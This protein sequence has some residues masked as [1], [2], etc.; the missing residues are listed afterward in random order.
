MAIINELALS[1]GG[2]II[3]KNQQSQQTENTVSI[4]IGLGGTGI[5][6]VREIKTQVYNRIK[7]DNDGGG[8]DA[9]YDHIK[10]IGVDADNVKY[11]DYDS[12]EDNLMRSRTLDTDE[13]F[14]LAGSDAML[15][16]TQYI[17]EKYHECAWVSRK[18]E[19]LDPY[20]APGTGGIRQVGRFM[21]M[22]K[23]DDFMQKLRYTINEGKRGLDR[24]DVVVHIFAGLCGA[25]GSGTFLDVCYMV[26]EV[27]KDEANAYISGYFFLP[28]V[29]V[30]HVKSQIVKEYLPINGY[31]ALQELDYCMNLESNNGSFRQIYRGGKEIEWKMQPVDY[32]HFISA[33]D[34]NGN[35]RNDAYDCAMKVASEYMI[36]FLIK[37]CRGGYNMLD[38]VSSAYR[39][40]WCRDGERFRGYCLRYLSIGVSSARIP[41]KEVNTYLAAEIFKMFRDAEHEAP[42]ETDIF[43]F[44]TS[45]M[46]ATNAEDDIAIRIYTN[47]FSMLQGTAAE[48][49]MQWDG[50]AKQ[51]KTNGN[52]EMVYFYEEQTSSKKEI[53][54]KNKTAM[55]DPENPQSLISRLQRVMMDDVITN[56]QR[57]P[58]FGYNILHGAGR[59]SLDNIIDSLLTI[60]SSRLSDLQQYTASKEMYCS[61][62]HD[63]FDNSGFF[64]RGA[65]FKEYVRSVY[66]ME[67]QRYREAAYIQMEQML[68]SFKLQ[69][70]NIANDFYGT[71]ARIYTDLRD[72]F[73]DNSTILAKGI[74]VN[75][76]KGFENSLI[77]INDSNMQE[78]LKNEL[79]KVAPASVF[80]F[81]ITELVSNSDMWKNNATISKLVTEFFVGDNTQNPAQG[82]SEKGIFKDF[83][84]KTIENFLQI[85]YDTDDKEKIA[86]RIQRDWLG[87]LAQNAAPL[88]H[89]N[90]QVYDRKL[91]TFGCLSVPEVSLPL[92]IAADNFIVKERDIN[93]AEK[94]TKDRISILTSGR[95]FPISALKEISDYE[96][97]YFG[98][99]RDGTH[100]Y[101]GMPHAVNIEFDDW[102]RLPL[103]TPMSILM[104]DLKNIP[105]IARRQCE[106][107]LEICEG[108]EKYGIYEINNDRHFTLFLPKNEL[109]DVI[110]ELESEVEKFMESYAQS[111]DS[112]QMQEKKEKLMMQIEK[113][114]RQLSDREF[115]EPLDYGFSLC[116]KLS[117]PCSKFYEPSDYGFSLWGEVHTDDDVNRI[118]LDMLCYS[119]VI[120]LEAWKAI[121]KIR[122][123]DEML[124]DMNEKLQALNE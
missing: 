96:K 50:N 25:V 33:T 123:A 21:M 5:D 31:A 38:W 101:E 100:Y 121:S 36:E 64:S 4:I 19:L 87:K 110:T 14:L 54:E 51:M 32:C 17:Q 39:N 68:N 61:K 55:L 89:L 35:V 91:S 34:K 71:L 57:G 26:R 84:D 3:S 74:A 93:I 47:L 67:Q 99:T 13:M 122:Q 12:E 120:L 104:S 117:R 107:Q 109:D 76:I 45:V 60:N 97:R 42:T 7:P 9:K 10:F 106:R 63:V 52:Q 72:T 80:R 62:A 27:L 112:S 95:G 77:D 44:A 59:Y 116:Q 15:S 30:A 105:E 114:E 90:T 65:A 69:V 29:N 22:S 73:A 20:K 81:F 66:D 49:Y 16:R 2:G 85:V 70:S 41:M 119:P 6:C 86:D 79:R 53:I 1:R 108:I 8:S 43:N 82:D 28:D 48:N 94:V 124:K 83:A 46:G 40:A 37:E 88:L 98:C 113:V 58:V 118:K 78:S 102:R 11:D 111:I 56:I 115:Y 18:M 92:R 23:S 75:E 103:L 24:P